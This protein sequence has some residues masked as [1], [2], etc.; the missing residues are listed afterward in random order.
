MP[1]AVVTPPIILEAKP[2]IE[3]ICPST[4]AMSY[5]RKSKLPA[6][7]SISTSTSPAGLVQDLTFQ[8]NSKALAASS[9]AIALSVGSPFYVASSDDATVQ[10]RNTGWRTTYAAARMAVETAKESSDMFLPLKA[11]VG[12]MSV[13][14]NNYDVSVSCS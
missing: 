6:D 11:V 13:L 10:G 4:S 2:I 9:I 12:V 3:L 14:M 8:R 5:L 7:V 1:S